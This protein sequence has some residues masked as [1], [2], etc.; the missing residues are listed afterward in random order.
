MACKIRQKS[1][2]NV[3]TICYTLSCA[4]FCIWGIQNDKL[5]RHA[6]V[7]EIVK[8]RAV[9][10][11]GFLS[12]QYL[13]LCAC[14]SRYWPASCATQHPTLLMTLIKSPKKCSSLSLFA[15]PG[16]GKSSQNFCGW[17][18]SNHVSHLLKSKLRSAPW[19]KLAGESFFSPR[20]RLR[21]ALT[22]WY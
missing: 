20:R 7:T 14:K 12:W 4:C 16:C 9:D 19:K 10:V 2:K 8:R 21:D 3:S 11:A 22:Q 18:I 17:R 6:V 13:R 15:R 1:I 5:Y